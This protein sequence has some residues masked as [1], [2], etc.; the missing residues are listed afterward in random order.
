MSPKWFQKRSPRV[1]PEALE[2]Q[3][4]ESLKETRGQQA[5]VNA[6]TSYLELRKGQNGFGE[7]FDI[8]I[9]VPRSS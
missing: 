2:R 6:L 8:T 5:R 7:D 3:A 9:L 4:E 1:D